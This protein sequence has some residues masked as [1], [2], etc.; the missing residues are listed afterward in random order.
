MST[1]MS[2]RG[3]WT[4]LH[5]KSPPREYAHNFDQNERKKTNG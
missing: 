4:Y 2:L 1:N 3:Q 5:P